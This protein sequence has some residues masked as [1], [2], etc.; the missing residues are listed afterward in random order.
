[1]QLVMLPNG[2]E[3]LTNTNAFEK[4]DRMSWFV[5]SWIQPLLQEKGNQVEG[6][7]MLQF[8]N[9]SIEWAV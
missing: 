9:Q 5:S 3:R 7:G 1:M 8:G 4:L 2:K 6:N